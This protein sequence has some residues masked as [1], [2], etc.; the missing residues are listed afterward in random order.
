MSNFY[1]FY[2]NALLADSTYALNEDVINGISGSAL[3]ELLLKRMTRPLSGFIANNFSIVT[4]VE[5]DDVTG[6]GFD[7]TVWKGEDGKL[8]V[9]PSSVS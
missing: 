1:G 4:H 3:G 9:S 2:L 8:Y 6:S 7:A 5:A